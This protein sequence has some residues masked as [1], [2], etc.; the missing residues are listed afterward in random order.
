MAFS[1]YG[2]NRTE[3]GGQHLSAE[4]RAPGQ[5]QRPAGRVRVTTS[6]MP[7]VTSS[8]TTWRPRATVARHPLPAHTLTGE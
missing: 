6:P 5:A 1:P 4:P 3:R 8:H 7:V 2:I